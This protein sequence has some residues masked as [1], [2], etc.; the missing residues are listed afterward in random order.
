MNEKRGK[1]VSYVNESKI[2][3]Y[4][5]KSFNRK[6]K[7]LIILIELR[8]KDDPPPDGSNVLTKF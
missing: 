3:I 8:K 1:L 7:Y 4:S 2:D 5:K 6:G